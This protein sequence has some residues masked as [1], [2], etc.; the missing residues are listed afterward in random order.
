MTI[1]KRIRAILAEME[2][3]ELRA[4]EGFNRSDVAYAV[5]SHCRNEIM[6]EILDY[7]VRTINGVVH[8]KRLPVDVS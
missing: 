1:A 4:L 5:A 2:I 3:G 6:R 7:D 8:V